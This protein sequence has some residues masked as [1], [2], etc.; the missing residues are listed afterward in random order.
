MTNRP[1][2]RTPDCLSGERHP[3]AM[4]RSR[5]TGRRLALLEA[6]LGL[7]AERGFEGLRTREVAE[8]VGVHP[9]MLHYHFATKEALV[10]AV[11]QELVRRLDESLLPRDDAS[12]PPARVLHRYL[13]ALC[14]R[15]RREPELFVTLGEFYLRAGRYPA[16]ARVLAEAEQ[17]WRRCLVGLMRGGVKQGAFRPDL[18]GEAAA[19]VLFAFLKGSAL[20]AGGGGPPKGAV[21]QLERW[22]TG[23]GKGGGE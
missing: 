23:C 21:A 9:A 3:A 19:E 10:E 16:L 7:I 22:I 11:V 5:V 8:R 2:S 18:D 6:A 4:A 14:A 17:G 1:V 20:A 12:E 15:M 13:H